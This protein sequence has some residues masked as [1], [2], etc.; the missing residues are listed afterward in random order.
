MATADL[1]KPVPTEPP[2]FRT[3]ADVQ[4]HLGGVPAH[5]IRVSPSPGYAT[6]KDL[7]EVHD[8]ESRICEL[9]DGILVEKDMATYE[10]FLAGVLLYFIQI[11]LEEND[12]GVALPG[13]G[14]LRLPSGRV[15]APDVSFISWKRMPNRRFP[16]DAIASLV[17]D[18]AVEVLSPGN[19][20][21]EMEKKLADYFDSGGKLVWITD[22]SD[23][24]VRV[25]TSPRRS[26]LLTEEDTLDGK[27]VL[28]GF[29]LPIKKWFA[30]ASRRPRQ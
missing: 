6:E 7:L 19:T 24:T 25:Y 27:K 14:W 30:R 23:R 22:P 15:R 29:T 17:P 20:E 9:I 21:G 13:D 28:P 12:L 18:L 10:A 3:L 11:Y 4:D 26:V 16:E 2:H 1:P 5:R 8:K